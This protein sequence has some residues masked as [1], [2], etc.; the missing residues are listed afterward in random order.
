MRL[1]SDITLAQTRSA[2]LVEARYYGADHIAGWEKSWE[3]QRLF[4]W[5]SCYVVEG[6]RVFGMLDLFPV[7]WDYFRRLLAGETDTDALTPSDIV[8]LRKDKPGSYP[9][10]LLTV[11]LAE[12]CRGEGWLRRMFLDR[13]AFFES[14][15]ARG[16]S[17]PEVVTENF[18]EDGRRFS[19][20]RGFRLVAE[21][22]RGGLV[23]A[24]PW[25][26]FTASFR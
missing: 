25:A 2:D 21:Q 9:M 3:W 8:D 22:H 12:E 18:T 20:S 15:E 24:M 4:P 23:Y 6:D 1:T 10:L 5:M 16:F 26:P 17:F 19:E 11:I 7:H 14:L 13:V